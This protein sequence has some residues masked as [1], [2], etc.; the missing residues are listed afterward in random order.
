M[1]PYLAFLWFSLCQNHPKVF[2]VAEVRWYN[3]VF[4]FYLDKV[5]Y[6]F[7]MPNELSL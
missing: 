4:C 5:M 6:S 1:G 7:D 2:I 3:L